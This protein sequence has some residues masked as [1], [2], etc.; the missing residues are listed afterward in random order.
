MPRS[1]TT[2][3]CS[4][5]CIAEVGRGLDF[6]RSAVI[7][8]LG[9][10][11]AAYA[12]DAIVAVA[13]LD[14]PLQD[15]AVLALGRIGDARALPALASLTAVRPS[16]A[17]TLAAAQCLLGDKCEAR[18][19]ALADAGGCAD[20]APAVSTRARSPCSASLPRAGNHAAVDALV[21]L[22]ARRP[23]AMRDEAA[24]GVGDVALRDPPQMI[25]WLDAAPADRRARAIELLKDGFDSL[26]EDFA[27]EQFFAA[28]RA[29]YWKAPEGS[30]DARPRL[31]TLI[32]KLEF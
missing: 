18:I 26:E 21:D 20:D 16:A 29:A 13:Q 27:E 15:D 23:A 11:R 28:A 6:F 14:G 9:E 8:A 10:H 17:P 12:V 1:A 2:R 30:A 3:R 24:L 22:G 5:R 19:K 4:A 7:D 32:Q 31:A 25:A